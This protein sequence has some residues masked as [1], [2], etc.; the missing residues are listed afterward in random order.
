MKRIHSEQPNVRRERSYSEVLGTQSARPRHGSGQ[1]YPS[2]R[3]RRSRHDSA[4]TPES[5]IR[6]T[7][8]TLTASENSRSMYHCAGT[9]CKDLAIYPGELVRFRR[10]TREPLCQDCG[11]WPR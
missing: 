2:F 8:V 10:A 1:G 6:M 3:D 7:E 11:G 5:A 9:M 4:F